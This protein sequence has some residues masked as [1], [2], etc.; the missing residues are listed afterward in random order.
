MS[1]FLNKISDFYT[2]IHIFPTN[3]AHVLRPDDVAVL[4]NLPADRR[5]SSFFT[6]MYKEEKVLNGGWFMNMH[7]PPT[8][9]IEKLMD[10]TILPKGIKPIW[11]FN[12]S[13]LGKYFSYVF[14]QEPIFILK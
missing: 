9:S 1:K 13:T 7:E 12:W 10:G 11:L 6:H 4:R 8:P 5:S 3:C 14:I 2:K